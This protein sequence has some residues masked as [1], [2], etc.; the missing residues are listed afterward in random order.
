MKPV[1]NTNQPGISLSIS[2][3]EPSSN[4][5]DG[6]GEGLALRSGPV[7]HEVRLRFIGKDVAVA[8]LVRFEYPPP[9]WH[10]LTR[11]ALG[12]IHERRPL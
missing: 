8:R 1:P 7:D 11:H 10:R 2:L 5:L 6:T 9:V 3:P 4:A 12:D